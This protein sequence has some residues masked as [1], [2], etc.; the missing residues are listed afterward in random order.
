[1]YEIFNVGAVR[2]SEAF[3]LIN[4]NSTA[5][6]DSGFA[7][8]ADEMI[9]NIEK[10]LNGSKL[11]NILLTHSHYD[12]A[13]AVPY[14][15]RHFPNVK[16]VAGEYTK[17][18]FE[19]PSAKAL[20]WELD[21]KF[22]RKNGISEYDNLSDELAVDI[23]VCDGEIICA[24]NMK[25]RAL[26]LPGHTKC[27]FGY[28]LESED[29]L[30]SSESLGVYT[31]EKTVI[32][33]Y[34][35]GYKMSLDSIDRIIGLHPEKILIPHYGLVCGE[36]AADYLANARHSAVETCAE[37]ARILKAQGSHET[38]IE[39][40]KSKF[41]KGSVLDSYPIDA[42][43]LNTSITIRLIEKELL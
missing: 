33:S 8:C 26:S 40:F 29:M 36:E 35:V 32:P 13:L 14:I 10:R 12:H 42:F 2:G 15:K 24:G 6:I 5:L 25:F 28:Y 21:Q 4:D 31:L 9:A 3:L 37:I 1:M 11:D 39:F 20:M 7:F 22:A 41:Y 38:A 34:L 27:S 17:K 18:I 23:P 30:L 43:Y 19:K 16:V